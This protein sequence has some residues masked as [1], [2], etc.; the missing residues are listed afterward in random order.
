MSL[1]P[2][3]DGIGSIS[4]TNQGQKDSVRNR[5]LVARVWGSICSTSQYHRFLAT[6]S[7]Q[8]P[9]PLG[10]Y[11]KVSPSPNI[12][13]TAA[14]A[15]TRL[16]SDLSPYHVLQSSMSNTTNDVLPRLLKFLARTE[17]TSA[18]RSLRRDVRDALASDRAT[19]DDVTLLVHRAARLGLAPKE[20][21]L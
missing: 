20:V 4:V 15:H 18:V 9:V 8:V 21:T 6:K 17:P 13:N 7:T 16:S 3:A 11:A 5:T 2:I 12:G 19:T 1:C 10:F 14:T